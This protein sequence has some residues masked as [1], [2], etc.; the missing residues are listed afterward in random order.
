MHSHMGVDSWPGLEATDD[1][2]EMTSTPAMPYLR[3][4][5]GF[6]PHD[7][8]ISIINSVLF[9]PSSWL[10]SSRQGGVTTSLVLPGSGNLMGGEAY[11]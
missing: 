1:T 8:A 10:I 5:D 4:L 11:A 9:S 2:N 6:N 3:A 7:S